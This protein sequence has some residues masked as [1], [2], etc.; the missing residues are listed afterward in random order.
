LRDPETFSSSINSQHIGQF[1]GDLILASDGVEHR[2][3]RNLVAKASDV[4]ARTLGL[5]AR[6]STIDRLLDTIAPNGAP[7][8]SPMSRRSTRCR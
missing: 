7:S 2:K 1:M 8:S 5:D 6:R 3:Y 4:A